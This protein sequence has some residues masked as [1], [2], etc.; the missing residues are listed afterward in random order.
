MK[1]TLPAILFVT[2]IFCFTAVWAGNTTQISGVVM[3]P[4]SMV[5]PADFA[6]S[7]TAN[8]KI[9]KYDMVNGRLH[10]PQL[11]SGLT[12]TI[13]GITTPDDANYYTLGYAISGNLP[14]NKV[15]IVMIENFTL[16]SPVG[17]G[18]LQFMFNI[19]GKSPIIKPEANTAVDNYNFSA[20]S[21]FFRQNAAYNALKFV[22]S[23]RPEGAWHNAL[24]Y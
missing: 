13:S 9:Y 16:P 18:E 22:E 14:E 8:I 1:A 23:N 21:T 15:F 3:F 6:A 7:V 17:C 12:V 4:K 19:T 11:A 5:V 24:V 2:G 10:N 20:T